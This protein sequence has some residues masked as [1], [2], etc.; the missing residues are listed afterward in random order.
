MVYFHK[1]KA[2][3]I[4]E[5]QNIAL[6]SHHNDVTHIDTEK[7]HGNVVLETQSN[8]AF[9]VLKTLIQNEFIA[10]FR[11]EIQ[12]KITSKMRFILSALTRPVTYQR[13]NSYALS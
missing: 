8:N 10:I 1:G 3:I 9:W 13:K 6:I 5:K 12:Q 11:A 2:F 4:W 7:N